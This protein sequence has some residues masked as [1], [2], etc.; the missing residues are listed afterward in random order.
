MGEYSYPVYLRKSSIF[1]L[2]FHIL[3]Y[4]S[5]LPI[6][7]PFF[8]HKLY[9]SGE[10][11]TA[12]AQ[13]LT[14]LTRRVTIYEVNEAVL[15]RKYIAQSEQLAQEQTHRQGLERDFVEMETS[16]KKRI[17]YLEQ[18]KLAAGA[19]IGKEKIGICCFMF[20]CVCV[21]VFCGVVLSYG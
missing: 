7:Y 20:V 17:L 8:H 10:D 3:P 12:T 21:C 15:S 13:Q 11:P 16:L 5:I 14:D 6:S 19:R 9:I 18:Y 4:P 2:S 1:S